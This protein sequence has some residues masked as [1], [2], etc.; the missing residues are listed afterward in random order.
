M[1][2]LQLLTSLNDD[3]SVRAIA[4]YSRILK[5]NGYNPYVFAPLGRELSYFKRWGAEIVEQSTSSEDIIYSKANIK[6][7]CE[8][9]SSKSIVTIHVYDV[10]GYKAALQVNKTC[11]IKILMSMLSNPSERTVM[12][13][14]NRTIFGE[15]IPQ[16]TTLVPSRT[17]YQELLTKYSRKNVSLFYVPVPVDLTIYDEKKISQERTISLA[18]QWGM[19][20]KPRHIIFTKAH[21]YSK[22]WQNQMINLSVNL[23]KL[24][25]NIRP[26]IF[27]LDKNDQFKFKEIEKPINM[28]SDKHIGYAIQWFGLCLALIVL[29]IIAFR[30]K[31]D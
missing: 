19:L 1:N 22:K 8:V 18:T 7:I 6:K 15:F 28:S 24:P 26:Y 27:N 29:T 14:L 20:E 3:I 31:D 25:E 13:R 4:A 11:S 21:F 12:G 2:I 23:D 9:V 17:I 5:D 16:A 10:A 30:R